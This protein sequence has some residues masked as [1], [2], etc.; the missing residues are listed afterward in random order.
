ML[1]DPCRATLVCVLW[2]STTY[3]YF[4]KGREKKKCLSQVIL[5]VLGVTQEC[6]TK[7]ETLA[8]CRRGE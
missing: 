8:A 3:L 1:L 5:A 6:Q 4:L 7:R 2:Q